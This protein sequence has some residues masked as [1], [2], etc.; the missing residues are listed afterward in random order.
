MGERQRR[1]VEP[2]EAVRE[3][4]AQ[5]GL[6]LGRASCPAR[7]SAR[8]RSSTRRC[9][10]GRR[11]RAAGAAGATRRSSTVSGRAS[12]RARPEAGR[13]G[14]PRR[15]SRR[16][17]ARLERGVVE[18]T[19]VPSS[20]DVEVAVQVADQVAGARRL[21]EVARPHHASTGSSAA[22]T[23]Y[24]RRAWRAAP[25]RR[26]ARCRWGGR[27]RARSPSPASRRRRTRRRSW[28]HIGSATTARA[29]P[30]GGERR[31]RA[32][33]AGSGR[34][35]SRAVPVSGIRTG[36]SAARAAASG[37]LGGDVLAVDAHPVGLGVHLHDRQR[38]VV[39]HVALRHVR[40]PRTA[41]VARV[42][43]IGQPA[44]ERGARDE[45]HARVR[46]RAARSA[47]NMGGSAPARGWGSRRSA[48]PSPPP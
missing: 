37:G 15:R 17:A 3:L 9:P 2:P 44:V 31:D 27:A 20:S 42:R 41:S 46:R 7:R 4:G 45:V 14:R 34:R 21:G 12:G 16:R 5:P 18:R 13:K 38:V 47:P 24:A 43:P 33:P 8:G 19:S 1:Q 10:W 28:A 39:D 23:T 6:E 11:C 36:S 48:P 35:A 40:V 29:P 32:P 26:R 25:A 22:A 30:R